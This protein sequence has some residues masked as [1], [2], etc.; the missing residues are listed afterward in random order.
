VYRP[1]QR[2]FPASPPVGALPLTP[3][4][5]PR[6][7]RP[8][9]ADNFSSFLEKENELDVVAGREGGASIPSALRHHNP[10]R[11]RPS[12]ATASSLGEAPGTAAA[13]SGRG[14]EREREG[15]SR[16]ASKEEEGGEGEGRRP[17]RPRS[18]AA[19]KRLGSAAGDDGFDDRGVADLG[20]SRRHD[21]ERPM[22]RR[23]AGP[24]A[25]VSGE[26]EG[27]QGGRGG[28]G[29]VGLRL[30]GILNQNKGPTLLEDGGE[31][32]FLASMSGNDRV[33][34]GGRHRN[35]PG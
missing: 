2:V 20:D 16:F 32:V 14:V 34:S 3:F 33:A 12:A 6:P 9:A 23:E 35:P 19:P 15:S 4:P 1:H 10:K 18:P 25:L 31:R 17:V 5:K 24:S 7:R 28:A 8:Q 26:G 21:V 13:A 22:P 30:S 11:P 29:G 27:E